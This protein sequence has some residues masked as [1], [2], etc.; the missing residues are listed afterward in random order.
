MSEPYIPDNKWI[1]CPGCNK[2]I[3]KDEF[4]E[5]LNVCPSCNKHVRLTAHERIE[6]IADKNSF[7]EMFNNLISKNFLMCP[8]YDEKL[9]KGKEVSKLDDAVVCGMCKINKIKTM[10]AVMDSNFMMGSMGSVVGEKITRTVEYATEKKLPIIIFSASGGA[11]MQEGIISLM[12]MAKVS[13]SLKVHSDKGLLYISVLTDPTTGGVTAS[14]AMLGDINIS[15][16]QTLI[17]FAGLRVI[18]GTIGEKLPDGFQTA[19][20]VKDCGFIDMIVE[21][22]DMKNTLGKLLEAHKNVRRVDK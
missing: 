15:E 16:P 19:E 20:F 8:G 12:Q 10:I 4:K 13:S 14:Y 7:T 11:R 9:Q 22:K 6:L 1:K 3:Y 2:I 5:N 21:R 17:G 18:K